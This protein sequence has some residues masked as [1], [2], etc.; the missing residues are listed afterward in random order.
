MSKG[1]AIDFKTIEENEIN[2]SLDLMKLARKAALCRQK[3]EIN[4]A[5][6]EFRT[7]GHLDEK[8]KQALIAANSH[9]EEIDTTTQLTSST[10]SST[11]N[12]SSSQKEG[13]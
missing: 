9:I 5:N 12:E 6:F 11:N 1:S 13:Q 2:I 7:M 8:K 10:V 4:P 3:K